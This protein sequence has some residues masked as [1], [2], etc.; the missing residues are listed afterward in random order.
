MTE[1]T[2]R[3]VVL[4]AAAAGAALGLDKA[5][6]F[7]PSA[8]AQQVVGDPLNPNGLKFHK[9]KV[10][11]IEMT[12]VSDGAVIRDHDAN[13][14]KNAAVDEVKA[15]LRT[16]GMPDDKV[17]NSYTV[18]FARINGRLVMFDAGAGEAALPA[19]GRLKENA[20][21]AG[22][23]LSQLQAIVVTHFHPDHVFGLM[24]K[25]N[26]QVYPGVEIYMPAAEYKFWTDP[27]STAKLPESRQGLAKRVQATFPTWKNIIQYED[28]KEVVLG[29]KAV[30]SYGHTPGHTSLLLP[31]GNQQLMVLGDVTNIPAFNLRNPGWHLAVDQDEPLAEQ[32]RRKLFDRVVADKVICTGYHWGMPGAGT[33]EKNG[34]GYALVPV[35]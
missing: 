22:I 31:S 30:G 24:T 33:V 18:S 20:A 34:N 19:T 17:P 5:V 14:V 4:S 2:R 28:G 35:A 8:L 3:T 12:T 32:N 9:F 23:D 13:F 26:A 27:A 7:I 11:D 1:L 10:G 21:A 16:A 15:A 6:E 29:I 25:D